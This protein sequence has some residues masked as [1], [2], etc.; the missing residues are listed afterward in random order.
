M[1]GTT[2]HG[3]KERVG[4]VSNEQWKGVDRSLELSVRA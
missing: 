4:Y 2:D 3:V 1:L